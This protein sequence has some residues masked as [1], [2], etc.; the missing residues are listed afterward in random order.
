MKTD[1]DIDKG[2]DRDKGIIEK[3]PNSGSGPS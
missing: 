3:I 1:H 2:L